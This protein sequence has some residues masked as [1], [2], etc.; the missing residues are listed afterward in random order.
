MTVSGDIEN[1]SDQQ[2]VQECELVN[3]ADLDTGSEKVRDTIAAY[4]NDLT[5]L[6]VAGSGSTRPSTC[7]RPTWRPSSGASTASR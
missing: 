5:D 2:Q 6:G 4:L 7:P 3:L 1:Y